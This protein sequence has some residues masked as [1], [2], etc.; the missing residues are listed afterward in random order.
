MNAMLSLYNVRL[1]PVTAA[2]LWLGWVAGCRKKTADTDDTP[3]SFPTAKHDGARGNGA[4]AVPLRSQKTTR[5]ST[6]TRKNGN[7]PSL[8]RIRREIEAAKGWK[9]K[10]SGPAKPF[11]QAVLPQLGKWC[12]AIAAYSAA[13]KRKKADAVAAAIVA[14]RN[15]WGKKLLPPKRFDAFSRETMRVGALRVWAAQYFEPVPYYKNDP[16][17][18]KYYRFTVYRKKRI[19]SRYFLERSRLRQAFFVLGQQTRTRHRQVKPFGSRKPT[20]WEVRA[21]V[22]ADLQR[23]P[24][25]PRARSGRSTRPGRIARP[26]RSARRGRSATLAR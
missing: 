14:L 4:G 9:T 15:H 26:G 17:I 13:G 5:V 6:V 1:L 10:V 3:P 11:L 23:H 19:V 25:A 8:A 21:A 22:L 24:N 2:A 20:Y 18:L 7:L 12:D 16:R